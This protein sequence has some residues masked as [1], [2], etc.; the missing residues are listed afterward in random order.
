[1]NNKVLVFIPARANSK[2]VK[3]KNIKKLNGK[4]LISWT[5]DFAKK[6]SFVDYIVI[7]SDSLRIK[8]I[9]KEKKVDF[10]LRPDHLSA[11]ESKVESSLIYTLENF[12]KRNLVEYILL[13]EPTSPFRE[14][15]TV[16][17]CLEILKEK[18]NYSVFTVCRTDK[19]F[20]HKKKDIF[21]PLFKNQKRRRQDRLQIYYECGVVYCL[22]FK[23]FKKQ[24]K[25]LNKTSFAYEV[26]QPEAIDINTNTDFKIAELLFKKK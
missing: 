8:K 12:K 7:S 10:I 17:K 2:G 9:A 21:S 23:E 25:I 18:K 19:L 22:R 1:M 16:K 11:D 24:K 4:P 20:F 6:L 5:I 15:K 26:N 14:K 3:N 13:L